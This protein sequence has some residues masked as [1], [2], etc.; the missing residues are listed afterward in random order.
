LYFVLNFYKQIE[1]RCFMSKNLI[2]SALAAFVLGG[3]FGGFVGGITGRDASVE[4]D[5]DIERDV[6]LQRDSTSRD[7]YRD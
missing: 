2:F 6:E 7:I 5:R 4:R 3:I 1:K